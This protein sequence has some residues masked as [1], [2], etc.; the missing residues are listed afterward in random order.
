MESCI[1]PGNSSCTFMQLSEKDLLELA[2]WQALKHARTLV[3]AGSVATAVMN[4]GNNN[5]CHF[6]GEVIEGRRRYVAALTVHS[7]DNAQNH[8]NCMVSRRDG[9]ICSHSIAVALTAL[10]EK[11]SQN[12]EKPREG[13]DNQSAERNPSLAIQ[14]LP[15]PLFGY[16][17]ISK[18]SVYPVAIC[19]RDEVRHL[20]DS[21]AEK[22]EHRKLASCRVRRPG[23]SRF[24]GKTSWRFLNPSR[25]AYGHLRN[26]QSLAA[27]GRPPMFAPFLQEFPLRYARCRK[28]QRWSGWN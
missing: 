21:I 15:I 1:L 2:G 10:N 17:L 27:T 19:A 13:T 24:A 5:N 20:D 12:T 16:D 26:L 6:K 28:G 3:S 23:T 18:R 9:Q 22:V 7:T 8:C 11:Q 25:G 4:S 14:G